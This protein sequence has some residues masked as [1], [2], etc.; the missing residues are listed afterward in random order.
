MIRSA[1]HSSYP[2]A[3]EEARDETT[4]AIAVAEQSRAFVDV[5]T[6]GQVLWTGPLSQVAA[7]LAGV[8]LGEPAAWPDPRVRDR[9]PVISGEVRRT[10]AIAVPGWRAAAEVT[11]KPVKATL[12]GPVTFA[13]LADD[14]HYGDPARAA[15]AVAD[16]LAEEVAALGE[17]GCR[18]FQLEEPLLAERPQ[19]LEL[20]ASLCAKVFAAAPAGSTT[21]LSLWFGDAGALWGRLAELPGTHLGLDVTGATGL[22]VLSRLPAGKGVVLGLLD[23]RHEE[24]EDALALEERLTPW[25]DSLLGR[26]VLVGPNAGLAALPRDVAFEKLLHARYLAERLRKTWTVRV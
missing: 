17:A 12:P 4:A 9:R 14:R 22:E 25:R 18:W 24:V 11:P 21:I 6:D 5:V 19:D 1:S 3:A 23:A 15:A 7:H 8:E 20:T 2:V 16:A 10:G 13:R 26:D